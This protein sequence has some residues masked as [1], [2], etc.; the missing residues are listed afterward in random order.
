MLLYI[1]RHGE[2]IYDPDTLTTLGHRQAD[3]LA[4]R[5]KHVGLTRIF[6]SPN[7]RARLTAAPTCRALGIKAE[8]EPWTSEDLTWDEFT[9]DYEGWAFEMADPRDTKSDWNLS[10]GDRWY[11][12]PLYERTRGAKAG[13]E[14]IARESDTFTEKLGYR[15]EG[16]VYKI[17]RPNEERVALFC[18]QGFGLTWMSYLLGIDPGLF[19]SAFD[20]THSGVSVLKFEDT[21][22]GYA[23]P[24]CL[25][26]SDTS[27][28]FAAGL[29]MK[30][31]GELLF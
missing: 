7:G 2:P 26:L 9:N 29:P 5:L 1:I 14:R 6:S 23:A 20:I 19:W 8:I 3:A 12:S 18:H 28:L 4:E 25:C 13:Y 27:H 11:D 16:K 10:Y 22:E 21:G 31:N 17:I 30:Y 24:R 15:R